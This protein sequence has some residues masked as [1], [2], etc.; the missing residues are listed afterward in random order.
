MYGP[1]DDKKIKERLTFLSDTKKTNRKEQK[2]YI[3]KCLG[4]HNVLDMPTT[5]TFAHAHKSSAFP[6]KTLKNIL[7][8]E[9]RFRAW[10]D[11]EKY[12]I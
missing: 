9:I 8:R 11:N 7:V 12:G 6:S 5:S 3:K 1:K 10:P 2:N 4:T